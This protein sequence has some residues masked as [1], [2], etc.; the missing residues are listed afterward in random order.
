MRFSCL[1]LLILVSLIATS[2]AATRL[3]G[4]KLSTS[5]F[6]PSIRSLALSRNDPAEKRLLRSNSV[7]KVD[8]EERAITIPG[9]S[10][11]VEWIKAFILKIKLSFN[12][13]KQLSAWLKEKKTPEDVFKLLKLDT[14]TKNLLAN[15]NLKTWSVFMV[16]YNKENPTKMV[17][18][19]GV[20]TKTYG[21]EAVAKM[22]EAARASPK[23]RGIANRLQNL[24]LN[25]WA[26]NGLTPDIVFQMMKVGEGGV[27]KLMSNQ[28]LNVWFYF[29][30]QMNNYNP[31]RQIDIIKKLLTVYDDIPLAKAFEAATQ[32]KTTE[33]M[34]K[35]LQQAQFKKWLADGVEPSTIFKS[36][37]LDNVKWTADPNAGVYREYKIFYHLNTK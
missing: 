33:F 18:M 35:K 16:L 14:G 19:L 12:E 9:L 24:Q 15:P 4:S 7:E 20:L 10:K 17:T 34:G 8:R 2:D 26:Q 25:A 27:D 32:V 13:G 36:L 30:N 6:P 5:G 31:Y 29:F 28:G 21:G 37:N 23:T 11:I 1:V 22:I 3:V